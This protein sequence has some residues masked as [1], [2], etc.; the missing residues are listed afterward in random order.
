MI[1]NSPPPQVKKTLEIK[2]KKADVSANDEK[3]QK[4]EEKL[5]KNFNEENYNNYYNEHNNF[6]GAKRLKSEFFVDS[7]SFYCESNTTTLNG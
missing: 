3:I 7:N 2:F 6:Q 4:N 1:N 5:K